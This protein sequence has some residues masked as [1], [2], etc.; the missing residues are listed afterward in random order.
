MSA[1]SISPDFLFVFIIHESQSYLGEGVLGLGGEGVLG[2][3]LGGAGVLGEGVL[4]FFIFLIAS[5]A[6]RFNFSNS[7]AVGE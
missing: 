5:S 7:S 2:F 3:R 4:G 6:S 1:K